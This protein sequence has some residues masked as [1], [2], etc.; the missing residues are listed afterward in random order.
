[1]CPVA[2]VFL[3]AI[4]TELAVAARHVAQARIIVAQ[5]RERIA[6]LKARGLSTHNYEVTLDVF[7]GTLQSLEHHESVLRTSVAKSFD[8]HIRASAPA[9]GPNV[10][11][12]RRLE[13]GRA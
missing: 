1:M 12:L 3:T 6:R 13:P 11:R 5:Q 9:G 10:S 4:E 8:F 7:I 2:D